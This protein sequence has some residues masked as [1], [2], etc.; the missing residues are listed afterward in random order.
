M[1]SKAV[2]V[3]DGELSGIAIAFVAYVVIFDKS[4][5]TDGRLLGES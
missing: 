4:K 2:L 3:T 5:N 1:E